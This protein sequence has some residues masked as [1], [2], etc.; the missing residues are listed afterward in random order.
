M[1][2]LVKG[3][4]HHTSCYSICDYNESKDYSLIGLYVE[5]ELREPS[6]KLNTMRIE[7]E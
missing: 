1:L 3:E 4:K 7:L 6:Y 5:V 2:R